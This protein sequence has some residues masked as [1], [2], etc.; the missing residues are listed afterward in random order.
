MTG[1]TTSVPP[2]LLCILVV[3]ATSMSA[4]TTTGASPLLLVNWGDCTVVDR[5]GTTV[6]IPN[7]FGSNGRS[8]GQ[9][10]LTARWRV[11]AD[12]DNTDAGRVLRT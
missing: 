1:A 7:V 8:T 5:L 2:R 4:V 12:I 3:E 6:E 10:E 11:G 9:R